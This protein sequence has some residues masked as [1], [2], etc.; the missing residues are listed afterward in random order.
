MILEFYQ[1]YR[2]SLILLLN[3]G[4]IVELH[5][6]KYGVVVSGKILGVILEFSISQ[7]RYLG[8]LVLLG[9]DL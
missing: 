9:C 6:D 5:Q 3:L 1:V 7:L 8:P 2:A 4:V